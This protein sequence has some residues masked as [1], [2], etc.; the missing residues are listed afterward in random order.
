EEAFFQ[1]VLAA[2]SNVDNLKV[3]V[4]QH[5]DSLKNTEGRLKELE[6]MTIEEWKEKTKKK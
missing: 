5:Q 3:A 1:A 2:K 4:Q 6:E